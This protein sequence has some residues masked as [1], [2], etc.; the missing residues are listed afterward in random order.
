MMSQPPSSFLAR[1]DP[2]IKLLGFFLALLPL[3]SLPLFSMGWTAAAL[4]T[5]GAVLGARLDP[6]TLWPTLRRL[7]WFFLFLLLIHGL[8]TPGRPLHPAWPGL[9][10]EGL[11]AGAGQGVR[12]LLLALLALA[13][14]RSTTA[15][16]L[17][18]ALDAPARLLEK[19]GA[20]LREWLTASAYAL[21]RIPALLRLALQ[22]R[23]NAGLR[24][25]ALKRPGLGGRLGWI[26]F[27][28]EAL[29]AGT[30]REIRRQEESLRLRGFD[31]LPETPPLSRRSDRGDL[32][33]LGI[34]V[35]VALL[36]LEGIWR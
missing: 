24:A 26:A 12:L 29:L 36:S 33:L 23:E 18:A 9:T 5:L 11:E 30:F 13:L 20:P 10:L 31:A 28:G 2:R 6:G 32:L 14:A 19:S 21:G 16:Q 3:A 27:Q 7:T 34:A 15:R 17:L 4:A 1:R 25:A 8:M 22:V 35:T